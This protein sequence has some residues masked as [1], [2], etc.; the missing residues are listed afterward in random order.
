MG[1]LIT[2]GTGF[3]GAEVVRTLVNRGAANLT[4]FDINDS[5]QRLDEV[6]EQVTIRK[7]DL[8]NFS[9]VLDVVRDSGAEVIYHLGGMLSLPSDQ[10]PQA[11]FQANA[12]GTYHVLEAARILG[13]SKVIFSS[14]IGTYC[15]G[16]DEQPIDDLSLQRPQLFYGACKVFGEH[17]GTFYRRKYKI[18]FRCVRYPSIVGPGVRTKGSVQYTSRMIEESAKGNPFTVW[19]RPDTRVTLLYVKDAALATIA[20][21]EAP[22]D[23]IQMINYVLGGPAPTAQELADFVLKKIPEQKL[24]LMWINRCKPVWTNHCIRSM[25][26]MHATNGAGSPRMNSK[27]WSMTFSKNSRKIRK[28]TTDG[29]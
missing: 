6:A 22:A 25:I 2:G 18:D 11:A 26:V 16:L 13:V 19:V 27:R 23:R 1:T 8:G 14:T 7:G 28:G 24:I 29:S 9:Q 21:A 15:H 4:V 3:V 5:P 17:M 12:M 10:D 20:L